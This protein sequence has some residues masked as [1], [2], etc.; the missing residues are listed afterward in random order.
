M[1][2]SR[3]GRPSKTR[4]AAKTRV[5]VVG[6]GR[7]GGALSLSLTRAGWNVSVLPRSDESSK[8][9]LKL[10]VELADE[11][12]LRMADLVLLA[13]PDSV[14]GRLSAKLRGELKPTAALVHCAGA[15]DLSAFGTDPEMLMRPRGSF[16]PLCAVSD[17]QDDLSGHAVAVAASDRALLAQLKK[18]ALAL[19]MTPI[20]V[21]EAR[22]SAYHAGAVMSAGLVVALLSAAT[23]ALEEAGIPPKAA[24]EALL[25]LVRSAIRGVEQRGLK[26]GLTG[27]IA[28]GDVS[29]VQQHLS[30]LPADLSAIYRALSLRALKLVEAQ[31]P[32]ETRHALERL[33]RG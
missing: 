23:A 31:L 26:R 20:E 28:R 25:P 16:H 24:L 21:A 9:A 30:A 19:G 10:S 14:V 12:E 5:V 33:L 22:R 13:V 1:A 15:L 18:M 27:P 32:A 8:K 29:V 2:P 3:A 17:P 6:F 4:S 11:S 7:L